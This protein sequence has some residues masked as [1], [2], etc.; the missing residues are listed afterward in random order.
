MARSDLDGP[1]TAGHIR[2]FKNFVDT[3]SG[4]R[5]QST[6]DQELLDRYFAENEFDLDDTANEQ[7]KRRVQPER[8]EA[9]EA[10]RIVDLTT[11]FYMTMP[12]LQMKRLLAERSATAAEIAGIAVN[13]GLDQLNDI[14][15]TPWAAMVF[16]K[17]LLGRSADLIVSGHTYYDDF[18]WIGDDEP[19]GE[20]KKREALWRR[21]APLPITWQHLNTEET[22]P[23][24]LA[25]IRDEVISIKK[26]TWGDMLDMFSKS[27]LKDLPVPEP[28]DAE[29]FEEQ[30]LAVYSNRF[31]LAYAWMAPHKSGLF[32]YHGAGFAGEFKDK[33][34][35]TVEH[36]MGRSAIRITPGV[37]SK[38]EWGKYWRSILFPIRGLLDQVDRLG[39][40]ASTAAKFDAYPLMQE[41]INLSG[42]GDDG[43]GATSENE[44]DW[45][46]DVRVYDAGDSISGRGREG[47]SPVFQPQHGDTTRELFILALDRC[48]QIS[49]ATEALEGKVQANTAA[50]SHNWSSEM[51]KNKLMPLTLA[52]IDGAIDLGE[53]VIKA[54]EVFGER[55]PLMSPEGAGTVWLDP[56]KLSDLA[57]SLAGNW[58][59]K[60]PINWRADL[61]TMMDLIERAG[62][63]GFPSQIWLA[64]KLGGIPNFWQH[65]QENFEVSAMI[66]PEI[67]KM[68]LQVIRDRFEVALATDEGMTPEEFEAIAHLLPGNVAQELR[69]KFAIDPSGEVAPP[70]DGGQ[71]VSNATRGALR[72]GSPLSV[73]GTGPQPVDE[74]VT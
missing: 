41:H 68:Q 8:F 43:S 61:E 74:V 23:A 4:I 29:W 26:V 14:I 69:A 6:L 16:D 53:A 7:R 66:D 46:G 60:I 63:T 50:W 44:E 35:R 42:I 11:S 65:Y 31:E 13:E 38:R 56:D 72:A 47:M 27:D 70:P 18:P 55:I 32:R 57:P 28:E 58:E 33:I 45:E 48:G 40:R 9:G 19:E 51:A 36:G 67:R 3:D 25:T 73:S 59:P 5:K 10:A 37:T 30:D 24:S 49:G 1:A 64:D 62:V 39:S 15:D 17:V 20:W 54:T 22:W 52:L 2:E 12:L 21:R 34:I 71:G